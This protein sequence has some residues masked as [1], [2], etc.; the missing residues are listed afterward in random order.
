MG[1]NPNPA[2]RL[3]EIQP[4]TESTS[5]AIIAG[6]LPFEVKV[7]PAKTPAEAGWL[8]RLTWILILVLSTLVAT[9]F[10]FQSGERSK[11]LR[12]QLA[13]LDTK[14]PS[15]LQIIYTSHKKKN[16]KRKR[17]PD[18]ERFSIFWLRNRDEKFSYGFWGLFLSFVATAGFLFLTFPEVGTWLGVELFAQEVRRDCWSFLNSN[19]GAVSFAGTVLTLAGFSAF[20][21]WQTFEAKK[22]LLIESGTIQSERHE[23]DRRK[24]EAKRSTILNDQFQ[25]PKISIGWWTEEE[26]EIEGFDILQQRLRNL[27]APEFEKSTQKQQKDIDKFLKIRSASTFAK[28]LEEVRVLEPKQICSVETMLSYALDGKDDEAAEI[29]MALIDQLTPPSDEDLENSQNE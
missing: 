22:D 29:A 10:C 2:L 11:D 16:G 17:I 26:V 1:E 13:Q 8:A 18:R 27:A 3:L 23:A 7:L 14:T 24:Y 12:D 15:D 21:W 5:Q 6:E 9:L 25:L 28:I 20:Q 19:I 4:I